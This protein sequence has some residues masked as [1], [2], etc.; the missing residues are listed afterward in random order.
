[1]TLDPQVHSR[2]RIEFGERVP[3]LMIMLKNLSTPKINHEIPHC[4][5]CFSIYSRAHTKINWSGHENRQTPRGR[6]GGGFCIT[7]GF[8]Y[9]DMFEKK[10]KTKERPRCGLKNQELLF[11]EP[12]LVDSKN[13]AFLYVKEPPAALLSVN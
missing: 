9:R 12:L 10:E 2:E 8:L 13:S 1:M 5:I 11:A 4:I 6:G 7:R 3:R